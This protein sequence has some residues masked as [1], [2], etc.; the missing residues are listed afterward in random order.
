MGICGANIHADTRRGTKQIQLFSCRFVCLRGSSRRTHA[1]SNDP[2]T[3]SSHLNTPSSHPRIRSRRSRISSRDSRIS[4]SSSYVS[5]RDFHT[6][7]RGS[8]ISSDGSYASSSD[9]H[10]GSRGCNIRSS[11]S[12]TRSRHRN[13]SPSDL[14]TL[15]R[16]RRVTSNKK[17]RR[18]KRRE[19][20]RNRCNSCS[21]RFAPLPGSRPFVF[22]TW[23][24]GYSLS[25]MRYVRTAP[26]A[27]S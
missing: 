8:R 21:C 18:T 17:M 7:S 10:V 4:S 26:F 12:R 5:S 3:S 27:F 13:I 25:A 24:S 14:R 11:V 16:L 22:M 19:P 20:A 1:P 15:P 9:S 23:V 2:R 6:S